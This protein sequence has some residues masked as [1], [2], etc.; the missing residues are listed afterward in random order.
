MLTFWVSILAL[1]ILLYGLLHQFDLGVR[2]LLRFARDEGRGRARLSTVTPIWGG[3]ETWYI[4]AG[5]VLCIAF[6]VAGAAVLSA[7]YIPFLLMSAGLIL[8]AVA[9]ES[10]DKSLRLRGL[11]R[12]AFS[13]GSVVAALMQGLMLGALIEGLI[14]VHGEYSGDEF[15]WW[16]LLA[17]LCGVGGLCIGY[18]ILGAFWLVRKC[19][20]NVRIAAY[21]LIPA[22]SLG[23]LLALIFVFVY[24]LAA[25]LRVMSDWPPVRAAY[26]HVVL[27]RSPP[28]GVRPRSDGASE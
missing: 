6:P 8:R 11:R 21:G 7:F 16:S 22:L 4:V 19:E 12:A 14:I 15:A 10:R 28:I 20:G 26:P 23:S 9:A 27:D 1:S 5:I 2:I 25:N 18:A 3:N 17:V 13:G 24:S